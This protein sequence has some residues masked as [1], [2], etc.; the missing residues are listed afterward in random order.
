MAT[1]KFRRYGPHYPCCAAIESIRAN[2]ESAYAREREAQREIRWL[3]DLL[4]RRSHELQAGWPEGR[5][6]PG[7]EVPDDSVAGLPGS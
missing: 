7:Q 5:H 4:I 2:L 3:S 1:L 6:E